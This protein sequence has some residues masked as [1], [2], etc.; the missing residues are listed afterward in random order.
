MLAGAIILTLYLAAPCRS[1]AAEKAKPAA[2]T[3]VVVS[4][5]PDKALEKAVRRQVFAKRENNEPITAADVADVAIIEGRG[6]GITNLAGLDQCKKVALINF[7]EN[8]IADLAPLAG[9]PRLQSLD[10]SRNK[11][12]KIDPLASV[13]ALQ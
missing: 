3:N 11:I 7:A 2:T 8:Q 10:L 9:L 6:L 5:F 13:T 4:I 1:L 12:G